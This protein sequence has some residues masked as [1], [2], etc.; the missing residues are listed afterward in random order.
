MAT[1]I[2]FPVP[3]R[4]KETGEKVVLT[5]ESYIV[6]GMKVYD[7]ETPRGKKLGQYQSHKVVVLG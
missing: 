3:G 6:P 1:K 2:I 4:I 5:G 7:L